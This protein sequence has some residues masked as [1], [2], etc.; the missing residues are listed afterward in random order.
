M[1]I[2]ILHCFFVS[3]SSDV[4]KAVHTGLDC[5]STLISQLEGLLGVR[6]ILIDY[7]VNQIS[8]RDDILWRAQL[9]NHQ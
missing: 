4:E 2:N 8:N 1:L 6:R 7:G 5:V 3:R 9:L